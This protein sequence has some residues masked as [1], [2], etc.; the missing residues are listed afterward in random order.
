MLYLPVNGPRIA[1]SENTVPYLDNPSEEAICES[2]Q[3]EEQHE[4]VKLVNHIQ[5]KNTYNK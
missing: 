2:G 1:V 5:L 3:I 4:T